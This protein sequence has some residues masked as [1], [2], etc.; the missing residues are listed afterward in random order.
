VAQLAID[1]NQLHVWDIFI[2]GKKCI[3]TQHATRLD[4]EC[5]PFTSVLWTTEG[6]LFVLDS[7]GCV[8]T[9]K[10]KIKTNQESQTPKDT[11]SSIYDRKISLD[12][13]TL[14]AP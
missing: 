8:Y 9:V 10:I 12:K 14:L 1:T 4:Q 13:T 5:D 2:C 6:G 11:R 3:L 7:R